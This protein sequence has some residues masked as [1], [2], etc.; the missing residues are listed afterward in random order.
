MPDGYVEI[1]TVMGAH[2]IR[3]AIRVASFSESPDRFAA[4]GPIHLIDPEG[5]MVPYRIVWSQTYK[6]TVRLALTGIETRDDAQ[7][8]AGRRV[9]VARKDLPPLAPDT[10]YWSD[11]IGLAVYDADDRYLGQV[12]QII[13]TGANDVYVVETPAGYPVAEILV[14]AI[15]SV[16]VDID[17]PKRRMRVHLPEGLV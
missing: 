10:Y 16:V 9:C 13:P 17:V 2:G 11:L 4:P 14:P 7:A 6:Q 8:L 5:R 3:G 12:V 15:A 1:G